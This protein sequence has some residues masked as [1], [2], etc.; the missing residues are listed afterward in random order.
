MSWKAELQNGIRTADQLAE[1]L[2]LTP[3]ETEQ[4]AAV[5]RRFPMLIPPYYLSLVDPTDPADPIGKMCLPSPEEFVPGG[6][7]DTSGESGNTKLD[8]LQHKYAQTT[9]LLS[10]NQCAMYCRHC[11]RKR[12]VGY[13]ET[14]LNRRVD[15]AVAYVKSHP[16]IN[17][18]LISGGDSLMNPNHIVERYLRE[19]TDIESLDFLRFGSRVPVSFPQRITEDEE[20]LSLF[21]TY[22]KRKPIYLVTQFNH[23]REITPQS[24]E[25][26]RLLLD[27]GV[28]IRNQTVLLRGVNDSGEVL[29]ELLSLLPSIGVS[30]YY[31]FQ[32]RPVTGVKGHFQVPINEGIRIV[33][34]AKSRQNGF[35]KSVRYAMSHPRGKIEI[36][37]QLPSGETVFKFHQSKASADQCSVFTRRLTPTDMWLD[38]DL[39]GI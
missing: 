4:Y 6:S 11:F 23:P 22:A 13:S 17:N 28:Q 36:V 39:N 38:A 34:D 18:V 19:L 5:I 24:T 37:C 35:G 8:G 20:L 2:H 7:F 16:E 9:L 27:R 31:I 3:E 33:D 14:E 29:G 1:L 21:E 25:A 30:P 10:T 12:M 15:E 26:V 32:C